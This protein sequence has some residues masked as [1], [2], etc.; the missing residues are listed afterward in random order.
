[1]IY[2]AKK[3]WAPTGMERLREMVVNG[4]FDVGQCYSLCAS[5]SASA[6]ATVVM[7]LSDDD[8]IKKF[9]EAEA[10]NVSLYRSLALS[11]FF[12][13]LSST[14][15]LTCAPSFFI[16]LFLFLTYTRTHA[17]LFAASASC[18][19]NRCKPRRG[20]LSLR[21]IL[22]VTVWYPWGSWRAR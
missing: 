16:S 3:E 9:M 10:P 21:Q 11:L 2:E 17:V 4:F 7:L 19:T 13:S 5:A 15:P 6:S 12:L 18:L 14:L 20:H 1:M 8:F 22:C